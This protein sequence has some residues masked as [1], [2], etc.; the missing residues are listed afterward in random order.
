MLIRAF[1]VRSLLLLGGAVGSAV[2]GWMLHPAFFVL[3]AVAVLRHAA[4]AASLRELFRDGMLHPAMVVQTGSVQRA[5]GLLAT[6][7]RLESDGRTRDAV[8]ISRMP[9]R[10]SRG[11]PPW[12]GARAA[13]VIAGDPPRLRPLSPDFAQSDLARARRAMERIPDAQWEALSSALDQLD[14]VREGVHLVE[15]GGEPWYGSVSDLESE[16]SLPAHLTGDDQHV[17]CAGL[18]AVEEPAMTDGERRRVAR[19]RRAAWLRVGLWA[20]LLVASIAVLAP[21]PLPAWALVPLQLAS[22]VAL[23]CALVAL[24][25]QLGR[26][27]AYGRDLAGGMLWRFAGSP[28]SF[29]S[30]G[31]DRDLAQLARRG[32]LAPEPGVEQDIV[33]LQHARELLHANGAWAPRGMKMQVSRVAAPPDSPIK[34]ALPSALRTGTSAALDV[35]RRR[36]TESE[37]TELARHVHFLRQPGAALYVLTPLALLVLA[38]WRAENWSL[39]PGVASAPVVLGMWLF[40]LR[41]YWRRRRVAAKLVEDVDLGWVITVDHGDGS[42]SDPELPA[43]GVESLLHARLDWTVNR[44]PATWRR[45]GRGAQLDR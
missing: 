29:D 39:P 37:R 20:A 27:R 34:L 26:V 21:L 16:G 1:P 28:S 8:V 18:P 5:R 7:V 40:A 38:L 12:G 25:H 4:A 24:L 19:L 36:L 32:V 15:L 23:P 17:W 33:V 31:L 35:A 13:V 43:R 22:L 6:L 42:G 11:S 41:V 2:L 14:E 10:W 30:L 44:R 3:T 45:F 9:R